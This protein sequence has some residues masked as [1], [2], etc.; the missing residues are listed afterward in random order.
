[1]PIVFKDKSAETANADIH[2]QLDQLESTR[3]PTTAAMITTTIENSRFRT[4]PITECANLERDLKAMGLKLNASQIDGT[5]SGSGK[6]CSDALVSVGAGGR[7]GTGSFISKDG[8][9]ITNHHVARDAIRQV[10]TT[11]NDYL[12]YGFVSRKWEEELAGSD[13]EAIQSRLQNPNSSLQN[14]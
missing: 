14:V 1:M 7:G 5:T 9:I 8:L 4:W 12:H 6:A 3:R 13:Y 2:A 10:S 11:D